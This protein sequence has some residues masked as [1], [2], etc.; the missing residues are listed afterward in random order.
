M[1]CRRLKIKQK[2]PTHV[3]GLNKLFSKITLEL[4][5]VQ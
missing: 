4:L 2:T 3:S 5:Q 1:V